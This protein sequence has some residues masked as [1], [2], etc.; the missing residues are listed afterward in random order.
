M[1]VHV[2]AGED[3]EAGATIVLLESM[4]LQTPVRAPRSGRVREVFARV[5]SQVDAGA[6]LLRLDRPVGEATVSDAPAHSFTAPE[7]GNASD[8]PT[9]AREHLDAL[10]AMI[11]GY[12]VSATRART[13]VAEYG[14]LR[15]ELAHDSGLRREQPR[16]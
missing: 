2:T 13:L 8:T 14:E 3:V 15:N 6:P 11:T 9:R 1:A 5:N 12:D 10:R 16:G 4:K 7:S